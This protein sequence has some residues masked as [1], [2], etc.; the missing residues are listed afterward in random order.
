[1]DPGG[2]WCCIAELLW[3]FLYC[4]S[5]ASASVWPQ[6]DD[7][8]NLLS[9]QMWSDLVFSVVVWRHSS[10]FMYG[11]V[12]KDGTTNDHKVERAHFYKGFP[13]WIIS[14][15]PC[16]PITPSLLV[17]S[18]PIFALKSPI[19]I[20]RSFFGISSEMLCKVLYRST[21]FIV[22]WLIPRYDNVEIIPID[23]FRTELDKDLLLF[24]PIL[25]RS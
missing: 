25:F 14:P 1:M 17:L 9:K 16:L 11:F 7:R 5:W 18:P 2:A 19:I 20:T 21:L 3:G 4:I 22:P 6:V 8:L 15:S 13:N 24:L 10:C 12:W 23:I